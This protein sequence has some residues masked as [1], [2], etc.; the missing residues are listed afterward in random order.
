MYSSPLPCYLLP[1]SPKYPPQHPIPENPPPISSVTLTE[2]K[3]QSSFADRTGSRHHLAL[4]NIVLWRAELMDGKDGS[5]NPVAIVD[6]RS[7][8]MSQKL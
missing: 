3:L 2:Q 5:S 7:F 8:R 6:D 4:A 1:L